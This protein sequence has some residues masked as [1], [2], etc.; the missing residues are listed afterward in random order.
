MAAEDVADVV[1][2]ATVFF[3]IFGTEDTDSDED[4]KEL[5]TVIRRRRQWPRRYWV[6]PVNCRRKVRTMRTG[7][8]CLYIVGV[9]CAILQLQMWTKVHESLGQS[10]RPFI[11]SKPFHDCLHHVSFRIYSP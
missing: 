9:Y 7:T 3:E 6:H 4:A 5:C 8:Q 2:S 11:V 10:G 1:L